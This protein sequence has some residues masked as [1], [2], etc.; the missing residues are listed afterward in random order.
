MPSKI[1]SKS[2]LLIITK[3]YSAANFFLLI[4]KNLNTSEIFEYNITIAQASS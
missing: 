1:N 4:K 2:H 3:Q